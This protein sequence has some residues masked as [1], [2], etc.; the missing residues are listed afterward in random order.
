MI[1]GLRV[2]HR[3]L[4]GQVAV[5]WFNHIDANTILIA[6]DDVAQNEDRKNIMRLGKPAN[7]KLVMKS[8]KDSI[9]AINSGVTDK[10]DLFVVVESIR[11][12]YD[13]ISN[14]I[15][16]KTLNLGGTKADE[17]TKSIGKAVNVTSRDEEMLQELMMQGIEVE[18]RQ[19]PNDRKIIYKN[20]VLRGG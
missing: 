20:E 9:E 14:T 1:K 7:A 6:N 8:V 19:V 17:N 2:D 12:A 15:V 18:I 13:L 5:A 16:F 10:Y 4:H 11:D 3:L